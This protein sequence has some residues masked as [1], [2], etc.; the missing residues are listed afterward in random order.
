MQQLVYCISALPSCISNSDCQYESLAAC[1][2]SSCSPCTSNNDCSDRTNTSFPTLCNTNTGVCQYC[3]ED[4]ECT[5]VHLSVC[6]SGQCA[7]CVYDED[8]QNVNKAIC[9]NGFCV[10][11]ITNND[12]TQLTTASRCENSTAYECEICLTDFDC[13]LISSLPR[14]H[15]NL[16]CVECLSSSDCTDGINNL[17]SPQYT[18]FACTVSNCM[19]CTQN[20]PTCITCQSGYYLT[21]DKTQCVNPCPSGY[22]GI[23]STQTC[24]SCLTPCETCQTAVDNCTSCVSPYQLNNNQCQA[25]KPPAATLATTTDPQVFLLVFNATMKISGDIS[26]YVQFSITSLVSPTDYNLSKTELQSD[27]KTFKITFNFNINVGVENLTILFVNKSQIIDASG[28]Y[29]VQ[30][31]VSVQTL[32]FTYFTATELATTQ[33][34]TST[35]TAVATASLASSATMFLTGGAGG[36]LWSFLG[37]FQIINYLLYLNVNYPSNVVTFFNIFSVSSI[38]NMVPNPIQY[39]APDHIPTDASWTRFSAK[40]L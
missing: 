28:V 9:D 34:I 32:Q 7:P 29:T 11:C 39:V 18:C 20:S 33:A 35:G 19:A 10:D 6:S 16:G 1:D 15:V 22:A 40:V 30:N 3:L 17:C 27:G 12:C 8:C 14:C 2:A 26:N 31:S 36:M 13:S 23:D 24:E 37:M 38:N 25:L 21:I 4:N 5:S